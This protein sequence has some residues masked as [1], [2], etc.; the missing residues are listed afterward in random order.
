MVLVRTLPLAGLATLALF[1]LPGCDP[2]K[3]ADEEP[4][5][6]TEVTESTPPPEPYDVSKLKAE[7]ADG[8]T[9]GVFQ[10]SMGRIVFMF[11]PEIAPTHVE[12]FKKLIS[13]GVYNGT[14]FHRCMPGFMIQGGDPSSADLSK[15][16][17]WGSGGYVVDG[18]E[19][20]IQAEFN[21]L[22]HTRGVMSTARSPQGPDTASSQFFIMHQENR[23]LDYQYTAWGRVVDGMDVVD[24]IVATG[25]TDQALNGAVEPSKAVVLKKASLETWPLK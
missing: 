8:D 24:K 23:N 7:P 10:T 20:N 6:K 9:V 17:A 19:Q 11:Y 1:L 14:R 15:S 13:E 2:D 16:G 18:V 4:A 21:A 5:K 22:P 3:M 25:P 12:R